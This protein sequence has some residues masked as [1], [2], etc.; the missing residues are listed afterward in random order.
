M[1]TRDPRVDLLQ[2]ALSGDPPDDANTDRI[3]G[4]A[5]EQ[6]E[7]FGLRRFTVDD[8]AR[9]VGL[10]R[11]TIYRYFPKKDQ[12]LNAL[13]MRELRRFLTKADAVL[14]A[15]PNPEAKLIEGLNFCVDY[16]RGHRLLNR[17][18]RTEPELILPHLTV[19][20]GGLLA[21]ARSWVA[22][23][24]RAEVKAGRITLP[25]EDIDGAA[26]LIAR[27]VLSLVLTPE[28]V[29]PL[30]SPE[31]RR[32]LADLYFAPLVRSLRPQG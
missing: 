6:A 26:E 30:D 3:L 24:I 11:V 22:G 1:R 23:H 5:L 15:Q 28:T 29:L 21:A 2:R 8:V 17:L 7:D 20:A 32:R 14:A 16:L 10:S 19:K 4:A 9:R 31:E 27:N 12:L 18:L 13:I 25:D